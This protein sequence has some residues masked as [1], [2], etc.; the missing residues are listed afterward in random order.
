MKERLRAAAAFLAVTVA[1][2]ELVK[3]DVAAQ[4][5]SSTDSG[6]AGAAKRR[7]LP[8]TVY[9]Q[10]DLQGVWD[11]RT[12]TPLERPRE[13][14]GKEFFTAEEA[15]EY[16]RRAA[17]RDDGR[18]PGDPR[19]QPSVHAVWWLDY[20]KRVVGT[21]RTSLIAD[22][23]DG[24]VPALTGEAQSRLASR[25]EANRG[26]GPADSPEDRS[27]WE[28]CITRGVPEGMLPAGYNNNVQFIQTQDYV[29][30]F[31]EMIHDA[32]I[33]PLDGRP[34]APTSVRSWMG[35]SR[36]RWE[37][38]T[39]VVETTNFSDKATFRGSGVNLRVVERFERVSA[40]TINYQFT[41]DDPSTWTRP[42]TVTFPLV[43]SDE[44][45]YEYACHEGN[46]GL[47]NILKNARAEDK[48]A[49]GP[50]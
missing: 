46:Y 11:Y 30:I 31:T 23:R 7:V 29:V 25:R 19:S 8:R 18:P 48:A 27:L 35:D 26:R 14:A 41:V 6:K 43:K 50:F 38:D 16:E 15:A 34:H 3:T 47:L 22:P 9:G 12:L 24:R 4:T 5:L 44:L 17:Q 37:G 36:G 33:V 20:G 45:I 32:R 21:L 49:K 10:P 2:V 40:D 1:F 13:F 28:R 39:L 42:W